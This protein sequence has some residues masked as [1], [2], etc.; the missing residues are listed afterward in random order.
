MIDT[1]NRASESAFRTAIAVY[2]DLARFIRHVAV[3]AFLA[4]DDGIL[5]NYGMNNFYMYRFAGSSLFTFVVWDKSDAFL[6]GPRSSIWHNITDV[7][8][9]I[10]NRL[11][12]RAIRYGDL[13]D[14]YLDTLVGAVRSAAEPDP[15]AGD[16]RGWLEREIEREYA[17]I[18][19]AALADPV[20][21][22][23]NEEF[24]Q[25]VERLRAFARE[26]GASVIEEVGRARAAA[27]LPFVRQRGR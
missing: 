24:E 18:R 26:R 21:P 23:T 5:G 11:M 3:E 14:L 12:T 20:K 19:E 7:P 17:Q 27:A 9:G 8:S 10:R 4:D 6:L 22:Y 2:L 13:Y 15:A 25:E 16:T 1:I